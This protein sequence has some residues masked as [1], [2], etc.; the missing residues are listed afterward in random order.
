MHQEIGDLSQRNACLLIA[1][2]ILISE[3][4]TRVKKK[5]KAQKWLNTVL[6]DEKSKS[7]LA[8]A[9]V[10]SEAQLPHSH[11]GHK[12]D[13]VTDINPSRTPLRRFPPLE[14]G[15][16]PLHAVEPTRTSAQTG[17]SNHPCRHLRVTSWWSR[18]PASGT[19]E[20]HARR[21]VLCPT[22]KATGRL[23]TGSAPW[24]AGP[25][26]P[27]RG[28]MRAL[29]GCRFPRGVR[30]TQNRLTVRELTFKQNVGKIKNGKHLA[31]W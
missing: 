9:R 15:R 23:R 14:V 24:G 11:R 21:S 25:A 17:N 5:K 2:L 7:N 27:V 8:V 26:G 13:L 1:R 31:T 4:L 18:R 3:M 20:G 29:Q 28:Q 22:S 19:H 16:H 6:S 12:T 30:D 10:S